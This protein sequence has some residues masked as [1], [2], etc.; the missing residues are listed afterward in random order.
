MNILLQH[1]SPPDVRLW[2]DSGTQDSS[3]Q[4]DDG[5]PETEAARDALLA[6][7]FSEG[8]DFQF[9]VDEGTVHNESAWAKRLPQIFQFLF[10][11]E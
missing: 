4:G 7:G 5:L 1:S 10:S 8:P 9:F 3:G 6:N 11:P 2:L